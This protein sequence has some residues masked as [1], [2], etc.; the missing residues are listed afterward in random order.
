[1]LLFVYSKKYYRKIKYYIYKYMIIF[2]PIYNLYNYTKTVFRKM[3]KNALI[4]LKIIKSKDVPFTKLLWT[5]CF[6]NIIIQKCGQVS[7]T[8]KRVYGKL[9]KVIWI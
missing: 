3:L 4:K 9:N 1:M 7:F 8:K 5:N 6:N 2:I